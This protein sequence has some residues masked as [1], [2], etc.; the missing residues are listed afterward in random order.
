MGFDTLAARQIIL[1]RMKHPDAELHVIVPCKTQ[2]DNW[3]PSQIS[4]YEYILGCADSVEYLNDEY[5]D[6]CMRERNQRLV[7]LSDIIIAYVSRY[8]SGAAQTV[9]M[10]ERAGK[11]VYNLY[12]SLDA[13]CFSQKNPIRP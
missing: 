3:S 2:S 4:T 6:N 1:F 12:P 8:N 5:T 13:L 10:A 9:R 11:K 7:D